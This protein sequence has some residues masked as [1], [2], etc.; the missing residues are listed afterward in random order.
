MKN[1]YG[2][3]ATM[4]AI[5]TRWP[6][7][8]GELMA[9]GLKGCEICN[10]GLCARFYELIGQVMSQSRAARKLEKEQREPLLPGST[11]IKNRCP[12]WPLRDWY[13]KKPREK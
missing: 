9:E 4:V 3:Y 1:S 7:Y 8:V 12:I 10:A 6:R 13:A 11:D 5:A 2:I